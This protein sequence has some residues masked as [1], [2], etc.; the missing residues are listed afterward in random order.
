[1]YFR[2]LNS[3]KVGNGPV[4]CS[5]K[6]SEIDRE[7]LS[8]CKNMTIFIFVHERIFRYGTKPYNLRFP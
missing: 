7:T 4:I 6:P 1:M 2:I 8:S 5:E 3:E